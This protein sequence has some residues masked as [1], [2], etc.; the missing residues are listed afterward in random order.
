MDFWDLTRLLFRRWYFA[1]PMLAVTGVIALVIQQTVK[2][3][4]VATSYVQLIPA[5]AAKT[6][7]AA[8]AT[9]PWLNLGIY[10]LGLAAMITVRDQAVAT[11][12]EKAGYAASYT[13]TPEGSGTGT[14][15]KIE[16]VG[17]SPLEAVNTTREVARVFDE[18]VKNLQIKEGAKNTELI[19]TRR[20]DLGDNLVANTA[21]MKRALV[22][23]AAVGVLVSGAF[24]LMLDVLFN[25]RAKRRRGQLAE[26]AD[27]VQIVRPRG[28][29]V[30]P[31]AISA[32]ERATTAGIQIRNGARAVAMKE[33]NRPGGEASPGVV[34][35]RPYYGA[36][37]DADPDAPPSEEGDSKVSTPG[38]VTI[39]LPLPGPAKF[40]S[41]WSL[42]RRPNDRQ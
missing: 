33:V 40:T 11:S 16:V 32:G 26:T 15:T 7:E 36:E 3:D 9:N 4:Y 22:A 12:L 1:V 13:I 41:S 20:L 21:K 34:D 39:V 37:R 5:P 28:P 30:A 38:D 29:M 10:A 31:V 8:S 18:A 2:P 24:T 17:A 6:G 42:L 23:V 27:G 14:I 35:H 25:R 19:T